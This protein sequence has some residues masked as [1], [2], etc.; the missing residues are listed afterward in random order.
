M[1]TSILLSRGNLEAP[2]NYTFENCPS[3]GCLI[4]RQKSCVFYDCS[5]VVHATV[6]DFHVVLIKYFM[7]LVMRWEVFLNQLNEQFADICP[8]IFAEGWVKPSYFSSSF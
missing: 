2:Y 4:L 3:L 1:R 6:T 7:Q 5:K 8:Y